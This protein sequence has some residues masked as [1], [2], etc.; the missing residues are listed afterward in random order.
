MNK[1]Y[2][3]LII[4]ILAIA[5]SSFF[6]TVESFSNYKLEQANGDYP[7]A[8]TQVLVQDIY[9][10]T[11]K[12]QISNENASDMWWHY[13]TFTLGSYDQIT[14]NIRH[15]NNPDIGR[16]MP[17]SMCGA[18]YHEKQTG[19]NYITPLPPVNPD[20]GTRVGYF[21]TDETII[22]SLPYRS[23]LPNILY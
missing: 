22:T 6:R 14:N 4:L 5:M 1:V 17:S 15:S 20:C 2:F 8:Q 21:T 23:E 7:V 11:N 16:C 12:N 18:L 3:L 10:P 9:P 19:S 13:P